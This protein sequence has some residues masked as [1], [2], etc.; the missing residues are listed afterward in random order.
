[1]K[2]SSSRGDRQS[3]MFLSPLLDEQAARCRLE[4]ARNGRVLAER[5]ITAF[6]SATR[7][8]GLLG[9][10][11]WPESSALII[12]PTNAI[13]TFFMQFAIDV[14]FVRKDGRVLKTHAALRPWRIAAALGAN[15]VIELS[16]GALGR[17]DTIA[18]DQLVLVRTI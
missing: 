15:A 18:G 17:A 6:D 9:L 5:V 13:H 16:A 7:R 8:K 12:A 14:A 1:M 10:E 2:R 11:S 4:N 3:I